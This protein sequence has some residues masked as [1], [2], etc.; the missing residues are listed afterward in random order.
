MEKRSRKFIY[1]CDK[2][3]STKEKSSQS[4][5]SNS[6]CFPYPLLVLARLHIK[7]LQFLK[8]FNTFQS[9]AEYSCKRYAVEI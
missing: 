3:K 7:T 5:C 9:N 8:Y 1:S 4:D 2:N 6:V